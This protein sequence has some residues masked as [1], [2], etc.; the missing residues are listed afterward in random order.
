MS[1]SQWHEDQSTG[2]R[3]LREHKRKADLDSR[4]GDALR[5]CGI[6]AADALAV[7]VLYAISGQSGSHRI[8]SAMRSIEAWLREGVAL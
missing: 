5:A 7:Q 2:E 4:L 8:V 6:N 3:A 1:N